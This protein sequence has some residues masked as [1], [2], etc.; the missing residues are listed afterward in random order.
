MAD[1]NPMHQQLLGHL[2]GA[3]DD[4][5]QEW[6]ESRLAGDEEYRRC[7]VELRRK[8]APLLA[9]RPD[10]E[11]PP[12]L[13]DRTC[14]LVASFAP[15]VKR[16]KSRRR[17]MSPD[18][19][20]PGDSA[21]LGW[22]DLT[23]VALILAVIGILVPPAIHASRFQARLASCQ[24]G[25]RQVGQAID[26]YGYCHGSDLTQYA[27]NERLTA[28]GQ[29]VADLLDDRLAPDDGRV[30]CPDAWLAAQGVFRWPRHGE[31]RLGR[32]ERQA[33]EIPEV[34]PS[35]AAVPWARLVS[36]SDSDW[37]GSG[38][39]RN[40]TFSGEADSIPAAV[41]ILTDAPSADLPGQAL[42]CHEGQGRNMFFEDGHVDFLPNSVPRD[43]A[44]AIPSR[45]DSPAMPRV[46]VPVSFAGWH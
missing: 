35:L 30:L 16:T 42:E 3:L 32:T 36:M 40:G 17:G 5:E 23:A 1:S 29:M 6:V 4:D 27:D 37:S 8:M 41:A 22:L 9:A 15:V 31:P 43:S 11:P 28:A 45:D 18:W 14:R 26:Q 34:G 46:T 12:G 25:L 20:F 39:W 24:D 13:A 7:W 38:T 44:D 33:S 21:R 2:L 19:T 10:Y